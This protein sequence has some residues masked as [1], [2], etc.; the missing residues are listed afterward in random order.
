MLQHARG[1]FGN[2]GYLKQVEHKVGQATWNHVLN[3]F[4][5]TLLWSYD[6]TTDIKANK[7]KRV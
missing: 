1:Y 2:Q 5:S 4:F 3:C 6:Y 7:G